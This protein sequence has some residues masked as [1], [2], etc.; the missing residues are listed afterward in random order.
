MPNLKTDSC[1]YEDDDFV[2]VDCDMRELTVTITLH[3]YRNLIAS[4]ACLLRDVQ[5]L[6][7]DKESAE[8][9]IDAM[10]ALIIAKAPDIIQEIGTILTGF[11]FPNGT[12]K[13]N[14]EEES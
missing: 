3:E 14:T 4:N 12:A 10:T 13:E 1:L 2:E 11:L 5:K 7:E 8:E 6:E 9:K